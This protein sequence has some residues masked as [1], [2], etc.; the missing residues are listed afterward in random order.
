MRKKLLQMLLIAALSAT[1]TSCSD[2]DDSDSTPTITQKINIEDFYTDNNS[3]GIDK[4]LAY[5]DKYN[6]EHNLLTTASEIEFIS[7]IDGC[8]AEI[9][10]T[11]EQNSSHITQKIT[12][13]CRVNTTYTDNYI[14]SPDYL[15]RHYTRTLIV[16]RQ[17]ILSTAVRQY[18]YGKWSDWTYYTDYY[19]NNSHNHGKNIAF[20]GG[21][22]AHNLRDGG[23]GEN[24]F[25]FEYNG[26]TISL[27]NLIADI[28]ACKHT[29]NYAQSGHGV[30][31]GKQKTNENTPVFKYNLYEQIKYA[32]EFSDEKNITYDV[33]MLFGG[34]NDCLSAVSVG[35]ISDPAGDYSYIA[36]F[37]K[38]IELIK[39]NNPTAS[40]YMLTS[41]PSFNGVTNMQ[42][43]KYINANIK[44]A[45]YYK[46][47][48]L[49]IYN[50]HIFTDDNYSFYYLS[51]KIHPNGEGYRIIS[52][53]IINLLN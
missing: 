25:G 48:I 29:G 17:E 32:F 14:P 23:K 4:A 35:N 27:Q 43:Q 30:F 24:R 20:F 31:T 36:S 41:F 19:N 11:T 21:S 3:K 26:K 52:P 39:S 38:A 49:D 53:Y 46:L 28:F 9:V 18:S 42:N 2:S 44:I 6:D 8:P 51:D 10:Q 22:F 40:I 50:N 15:S 5:I 1:V 47:P 37:K 12:T 33:F 7:N 16:A 13:Y 34:I 45:E